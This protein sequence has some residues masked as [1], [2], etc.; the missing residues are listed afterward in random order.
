VLGVVDRFD[1][2]ALNPKRRSAPNPKYRLKR[3]RIPGGDLIVSGA[4]AE[5]LHH[6]GGPS[7]ELPGKGIGNGVA[8][9][10]RASRRR[11]R[12]PQLRGDS[13]YVSGARKTG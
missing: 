9:F 11:P 10:P 5:R 13:R 7:D 1:R 12:P 2:V 6:S 8:H 3:Q 4:A